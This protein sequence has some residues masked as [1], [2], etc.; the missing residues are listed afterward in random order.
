M[1]GDLPDHVYA[2]LS[3]R[4]KLSKEKV[5]LITDACVLVRDSAAMSVLAA[6]HIACLLLKAPPEHKLSAMYLIEAVTTHSVAAGARSIRD[7]AEREAA[8][9]SG[10]VAARDPYVTRFTTTLPKLSREIVRTPEA[11]LPKV[12]KLMDVWRERKTF[13]SE[14]LRN[15]ELRWLPP[16]LQTSSSA[17]PAAPSPVP[18]ILSSSSSMRLQSP[19]AAAA[20]AIPQLPIA[21]PVATA[22]VVSATPAPDASN[23][24]GINI[25]QS[26][27]GLSSLMSSVAAQ[28]PMMVLPT[29]AAPASGAPT[30]A[31]MSALLAH[32]AQNSAAGAPGFPFL[33]G[34]GALAP[35]G[36]VPGAMYQ[37][38]PLPP[39]TDSTHGRD[40][41]HQSG[42]GDS[43]YRNSPDHNHRSSRYD[44]RN[45]NYG[46]RR[47]SSP[48]RGYSRSSG[49][50]GRGRGRDRSPERSSSSLRPPRSIDSADLERHL[51]TNWRT[52]TV[53]RP[54]LEFPQQQDWEAG[55]NCIKVL[56][57]TLYFNNVP[58]DVEMRSLKAIFGRHGSID[59]FIFNT[60][61]CQG[62]IKYRTRTMAEE[63]RTKM[64]DQ[65]LPGSPTDTMPMAVR[66]GCGF[67]P[68]PLFKFTPGHS[69][70]D[71]DTEMDMFDRMFL[72]LSENGGIREGTLRGGISIVE[73]DID[74]AQARHWVSLH[75][76]VEIGY[77]T[78]HGAP[79]KGQGGGPPRRGGRGGGFGGYSS[80]PNRDD[81]IARGGSGGSDEHARDRDR[82]WGQH[83]A[84]ATVAGGGAAFPRGADGAAF[85]HPGQF[86]PPPPPPPAFNGGA[87]V[88]APWQATLAAAAAAAAVSATPLSHAAYSSEGGFAAP[89]TGSTSD[90]RQPM[91]PRR[92]QY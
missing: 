46:S 45:D 76:G 62:W 81:W 87:S 5:K 86:L 74:L 3:P 66:W 64:H 65:P 52:V 82:P 27:A 23:P 18:P 17:A 88:A 4:E 69:V 10:A 61:R 89:Q 35:P 50:D 90:P 55:P 9:K 8:L 85:G 31:D 63:A 30:M 58:R 33:A 2:F 16:A 43:G 53:N 39:A 47:R 75:P 68:K 79:G 40:G 73:P 84:A 49:G 92:S 6:D 12:K 13:S 11:L 34:L 37:G 36:A 56:S 21:L 28:P 77:G 20:P 42:S 60:D 72:M 67:G 71:I 70:L 26:L 38:T 15:A 44:D 91:D 41:R 7:R 24:L 14:F 51:Y 78:L 19:S 1:L 29:A 25:A 54:H 22:P 32:F 59:S 80:A 48:D 83:G 57:R